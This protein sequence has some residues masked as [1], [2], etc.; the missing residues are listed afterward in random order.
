MF[1]VERLPGNPIV[2]PGMAG[3]SDDEGANINGPSL[4]R[5]PPWVASPL[6]SHYLYFAHH[7]GTHIRLAV[8]DTVTGP[9]RIHPGGALSLGETPCDDHIASP[10][11][12]VDHASREIR[13]YYHGVVA[14]EQRTFVATSEDGLHF[15]SRTEPLG[16]FYFRVFAQGD[17]TYA[18]AK[19]GNRSGV[20]L[21]SPDAYTPFRRIRRLLP[22]MRHAAVLVE[23]RHAFV[24]FTRIG[25][26]PESILVGR[27]DLARWTRRWR[28]TDVTPIL[29]PE[30]DWEGGD[31]PRSAS[32][33]GPAW[34]PEH[35][36]RDPA[37]HSEGDARYL[38]YAV[39]GEQGIAIARLHRR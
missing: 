11:V 10:D 5:V 27:I 3:L 33:S 37:I 16:P 1:T 12:H 6:G 34:E 32:R 8:A 25:D 36:L 18:I 23:G 21:A 22:A 4:I 24:F 26:E 2:R 35:A 15:T 19:D 14:G 17:R 29:R 20:L 7:R 28:P 39:A 31:L 38:L 30:T 13:L 9:Y